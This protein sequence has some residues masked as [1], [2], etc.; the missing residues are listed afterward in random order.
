MNNEP[1]LLV[2]RELDEVPGPTS[3]IESEFCNNHKGK[4]AW[5]KP[6]KKQSEELNFIDKFNLLLKI[7]LRGYHC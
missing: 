4:N 7:G 2:Y 3:M 6:L 1:R 5:H